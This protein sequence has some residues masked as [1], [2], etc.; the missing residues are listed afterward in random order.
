MHLCPTTVIKKYYSRNQWSN[1]DHYRQWYSL[2]RSEWPRET[3]QLEYPNVMYLCMVTQI[4][5]VDIPVMMFFWYCSFDVRINATA[6]Y[7]VPLL[8]SKHFWVQI[9]LYGHSADSWP[10]TKSLFL[11]LTQ[12]KNVFLNTNVDSVIQVNHTWSNNSM[13]LNTTPSPAILVTMSCGTACLSRFGVQPSCLPSYSWTRPRASCIPDTC[14]CH[15]LEPVI[16][17]PTIQYTKASA[18]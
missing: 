15:L 3:L 16:F 9:T 2:K 11:F 17:T 13:L 14:I 12:E 1:F 8:F 6:M 10:Q 7:S 5:Y 18:A 4:T